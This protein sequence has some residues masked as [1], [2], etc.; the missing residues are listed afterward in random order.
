MR[1]L[2]VS[3]RMKDVLSIFVFRVFHLFEDC[4]R[5]LDAYRRDE[6]NVASSLV[7]DGIPFRSI[8]FMLII[9]R[10]PLQLHEPSVQQQVQKVSPKGPT[11][12]AWWLQS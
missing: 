3:V 1:R 12:C 5:R 8:S 7:F 9:F 6:S 11:H 2:R 10:I 4:L